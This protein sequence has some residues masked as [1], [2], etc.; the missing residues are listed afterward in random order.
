MTEN[1]E[2]E[3]YKLLEKFVANGGNLLAFSVPSLVD[4]APSEGL[5]EFLTKYAD[6]IITVNELTDEVISKYLGNVDLSFVL[7]PGGTLYHHRR[8]LD[9]GQVLFL[10]NSNL[11]EETSGSLTIKGKDAIELNTLN[12]KINGYKNQPSGDNTVLSY[13]IPP[14]GSLLLFIPDA[15][16][17]D[18]PVPA[19]PSNLK[20]VNPFSPVTVTRDN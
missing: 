8:M 9:D 16:N 18:Y 7:E 13:T 10:V 6:K 17:T 1:L 3:T 11:T 4:G 15:K 14:A 5:K 2:L 12:G 19:I 20:P